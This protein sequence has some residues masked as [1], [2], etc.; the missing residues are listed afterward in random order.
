MHFILLKYI[1][2]IIRYMCFYKK[3]N[4][5]TCPALPYTKCSVFVIL[6]IILSLIYS[7][8]SNINSFGVIVEVYYTCSFNIS[9]P[10]FIHSFRSALKFPRL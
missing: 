2:N 3:K 6:S 10:E 1:H 9:L 8:H 4:D 5:S 7:P